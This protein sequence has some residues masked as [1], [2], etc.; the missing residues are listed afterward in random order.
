[1]LRLNKEGIE[2]TD[3]EL[4]YEGINVVAGG[5][6][7]NALAICFTLMMLAMNPEIQVGTSEKLQ[8]TIII[9]D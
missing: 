9:G 1:M 2:L 7:T 3:E 4:I 6:E 8:F 5:S